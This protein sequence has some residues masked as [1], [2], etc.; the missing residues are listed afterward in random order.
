MRGFVTNRFSAALFAVAALLGGAAPAAAQTG[1]VRG[2]V[3]DAAT[4][5][6]IEAVEVYVVGTNVR[7][8]SGARGEF[9]LAGVP[10]G[11]VTIRAERIGYAAAEQV[12][13][14]APGQA[15]VVEFALQS[16]VISLEE[17]V[18][19]G[20]GTQQ[21]RELSTSISKVTSE[22]FTNVPAASVDAAL[23]GRAPGVQIT[24][25]A[26]NPGNGITVR[27]R[28]AASLSAG[29]DPLWVIDGVPMLS[30]DYSQV[31]VGGQDLTAISGLS[32]DEIE[33][34][35]ILKDAAAT[36]IYG[37]RGSNGVIIVTTKRGRVGAAGP[38]I[39]FNAYAGVQELPRKLDL[40]TAE[41]YIEY[42][43]EGAINDGYDPIIVPEDEFDPNLHDFGY[44]P[45]VDTDWQD[46]IFRRA[47]VVS[48][49][50]AASGG[51]ERL[52]YYLS[53]AYFD[54]RG[55]ARGSGYDR[56]SARLNVDFDVNDR[57][58]LQTSFGVTRE[59]HER[60]END[61]TLNGVVTNV[62]ANQPFIPARLPNGEYTSTADDLAYSN[63]LAL[64]DYNS[65]DTRV[66][67]AIGSVAADIRLAGPLR[68]HS[69]VGMDVLDL[70][71]L[72]WE[73]P[74]VIG[75]YAASAGGVATMAT[76]SVNRYVIE[77][78]LTWDH[79]L[80]GGQLSLTGGQSVEFNDAEYMYMVG[81]GF[82]TDAFRYPGSAGVI[83]GYD[84]ESESHNLVSFF[85]RANLSL[86]GRYFF[87]A[88]LRA[89]GSSRFGPNNRYGVFPAGSFAWALTEEPFA[90][91]LRET[92]EI[93]LRASYG[94][95]GNQGIDD[96]F[97]YMGRF[98]RANYA[99]AP[100][101]AQTSIANPNLKWES[102]AELDVG[103]DIS[104]FG[105][106]A[107]FTADYYIKKTSD[108]LVSRPITSTS[109]QTSYWDNL[110]SIENRGF[111]FSLNTINIA[112]AEADGLRWSTTFN[113]STN[114]NEVTMLYND[115]P[116][117]AGLYSI[118]RIQEGAPLSAFYALKFLGVDPATG[119]A[120]YEDLDGD[121]DITADDRQIVGSPHPDWWGGMT[122]EISF[123]GIDL[124]AVLEFSQGAEVFN[125][126]RIF[127]DDGGYN[128][129]NKFANVMN[130]WRQPGD[131]T[132]EPRAS[133]EGSSGA[134]EVSSRFLEDGSYI[135]LQEVTIGYRLPAAVTHRFGLH[136]ARIYVS[137]HNL[138]LWTDYSGY[139]P[140]VN[141]NGSGSI[142]G[143]GTDFYAYPR[144]RTISIGISGGW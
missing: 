114:D 125:A 82:A 132:D 1:T 27:V 120:I 48:T 99:G 32:P 69:Q 53:G 136:N 98:G 112:A 46:L 124:R 64:A 143:L 65:N 74:K 52:R 25:N 128:W 68:F 60:V 20:Y 45:G 129:D 58:S 19:V 89:D 106:R 93:K 117:S 39:T 55:I 80:A 38:N 61:N 70:R 108:L 118:N 97:A 43:N 56:G 75:T 107:T 141:S 115:E 79:A 11:Q 77:N 103:A 101:I 86:A 96:E 50:I 139:D 35:D 22:E 4:R 130:R 138:K 123:R 63:A 42:F 109:G 71:E 116:F 18:V 73:S 16:D 91:D 17:V 126:M 9:L 66:L 83:T 36:A 34:I 78:Y 104:L 113:V 111:E 57:I 88:S 24:Q 21:R 33:S 137:G 5:A 92:A 8:L 134:R 23:Q 37:S 122:N 85:S 95:T 14:V 100:G 59:L 110:G 133:Y 13:T 142:T 105:G 15:A 51:T 3:T 47:P 84:A 131:E 76:S 119:D 87:T 49:Q 135:R 26:G 144:A 12:V 6:P 29:N 81:E 67:R 7:T 30:G 10:V 72:V 62:I 102:T 44:T 54:Q 2:V 121:G 28:G 41:E 140:D 94:L 31:G 127:A 40:L 90:G